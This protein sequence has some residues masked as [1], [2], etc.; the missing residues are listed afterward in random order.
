MPNDTDILL[1]VLGLQ[2]TIEYLSDKRIRA[3]K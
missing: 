1:P 2:Q 3:N